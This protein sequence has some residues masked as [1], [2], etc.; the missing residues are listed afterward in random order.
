M[1]ILKLLE[2]VSK[3]LLKQSDAVKKIVDMGYPESV[4]KRIASGE[5]P[6]DEA[7]RMARAK[8]QKRIDTFHASKQDFN[9]FKAGYSDDMAFTT[10][11]S[12]F[13]NNWLGKGKYQERLG[14]SDEIHGLRKQQRE[15]RAS[16]FD[17]DELDKLSKQGKDAEW[18]AAYDRMQQ[19]YKDA[20]KND[21]LPDRVYDTIYPMMPKAEKTFDPRTDY[22][23]ILPVLEKS[24]GKLSDD[25]IKSLKRGD[26]LWYE[27]KDVAD[28]LRANGYDSILLS[29]SGGDITTLASLYPNTMRSKFAAF[30]DEYKGSSILGAL[31]PYAVPAATVTLG[32]GVLGMMSPEE[33]LFA[34]PAPRQ[35]EMRAIGGNDTPA[36]ARTRNAVQTIG[37]ILMSGDSPDIVSTQGAGET[38]MKMANSQPISIWDALEVAGQADP[39]QVPAILKALYNY[40][41]QR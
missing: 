27:S 26:Y 33:K 23:K 20:V 8:N 24:V 10:P 37:E 17:Y 4:A 5:L 19:S 1:G 3:G 16:F 36:Q 6:M 29:E 15:L 28:W 31:A 41:R 34:A 39:M 32:S 11:D 21:V 14:A 22:E 9:E 7:S 38:L 13:A 2:A 30:D 40:E 25:T 18:K 12:E 35:P